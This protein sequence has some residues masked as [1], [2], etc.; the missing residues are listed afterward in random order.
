MTSVSFS[1]KTFFNGILFCVIFVLGAATLLLHNSAI[2]N[3]SLTRRVE[4]RRDM[5]ERDVLSQEAAYLRF[6]LTSLRGQA[7][8]LGFVLITDPRFVRRGEEKPSLAARGTE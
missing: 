7:R 6:S 1:K 2:R 5:L 4:E 8:E 3:A